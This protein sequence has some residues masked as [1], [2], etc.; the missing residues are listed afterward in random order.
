M[1]GRNKAKEERGMKDKSMK[2][3]HY[4]LF[5]FNKPFSLAIS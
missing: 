2:E 3:M 4:F 1:C 5:N